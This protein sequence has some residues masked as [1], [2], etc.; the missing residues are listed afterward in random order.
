VLLTLLGCI[1]GVIIG[2]G[3]T[4]GQQ[5][6]GWIKIPGNMVFES[7][8]VDLNASDVAMVAIVVI[9]AGWLISRM[10]VG[11]KLRRE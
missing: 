6:F 5:T 10:T 9:S 7:Y 2:V 4:L 8:P 11:A 3:F 1:V